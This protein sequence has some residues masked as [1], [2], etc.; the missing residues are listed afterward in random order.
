MIWLS[1]LNDF[2]ISGSDT[3]PSGSISLTPT[4]TLLLIH[5][6]YTPKTFFLEKETCKFANKCFLHI[7]THPLIEGGG[8]HLLTLGWPISLCDGLVTLCPV[9]SVHYN[10]S[11]QHKYMQA[12]M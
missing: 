2:V 9:Y 11:V 5:K 1:A 12:D 7:L 8:R 10:I 3:D 4:Q 6:F